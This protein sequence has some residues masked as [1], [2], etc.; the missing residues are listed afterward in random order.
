[1][2]CKRVPFFTSARFYA[3]A[4]S[5]WV[6]N[7]RPFGV[8]LRSACGPA[9]NCHGCP[10]STSACPI[11]VMTY[12]AAI[13]AFP[14]MVVGAILAV[15]ILAGRLVCSF[16]CP[17]GLVQDLIQRIPG[18]K[19]RMW[20]WLNWGRYLALGLLVVLLPWIFGV[21]VGGFLAVSKPQVDKLGSDVSVVVTVQNHGD[22]A[23]RDPSIELL[24]RDATGAELP[25]RVQ[26]VHSGIT[27]E[28]GASVALP[29][30]SIANRLADANLEVRSPQS[31]VEQNFPTLAY[32]CKICPVGTLEA[33]L[34]ALATSASGGL[35]GYSGDLLLRLSI[36][37]A[38]VVAMWL[39]SRP[40]C[41]TFCPL[42][43]IYALTSRF[44]LARIEADSEVCTSC[45]A[46]AS[47]CPMDLDLPRQI[48]G[49]D[50]IACGD[51]MKACPQQGIRRKFGFR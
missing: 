42:G 41:R 2:S 12:G 49:A 40:F 21:S 7:L 10:W 31:A 4:I 47:A 44:S 39:W 28:P 48:G 33:T 46:C 17:F 11:G 18:P 45:G 38:F 26:T 37:A 23:V 16:A 15:G 13:H 29:A 30:M 25:E 32:Y 43:A 19:F 3:S 14:A 5:A 24:Y 34:P 51:C 35:H 50:C 9:M 20:S 6:L 8:N 27:V 36:A 1:M 22:T